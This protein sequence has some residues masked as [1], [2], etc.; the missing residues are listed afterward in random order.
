MQHFAVVEHVHHHVVDDDQRL[1][2][3]IERIDTLNEHRVAHARNAAPAHRAH[4]GTQL[5]SHQRVNAQ[6]GIVVELVGLCADDSVSGTVVAL[7]EDIAEQLA[8]GLVIGNGL[9]LKGIA[10]HVH[11]YRTDVGGNLQFIVALLVGYGG[12][13]LVAV[14][15]DDDTGK[16]LTCGSIDHVACHGL[17]IFLCCQR[18]CSQQQHCR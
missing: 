15:R 2:T 13:P 4:I 16:G 14:G 7:A 10:I 11:Q 18:S 1:G 17:R 6:L 12:L 9:L 3:G 5:L 8:I